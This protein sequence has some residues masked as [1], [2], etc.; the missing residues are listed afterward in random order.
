MV[1]HG[2]WVE[3]PDIPY[4]RQVLVFTILVKSGFLTDV[5]GIFV[6]PLQNQTSSLSAAMAFNELYHIYPISYVSAATGG[7]LTACT[8]PVVISFLFFP[9]FCGTQE[10]V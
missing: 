8:M 3:E 6:T 1:G 10:Q 5:N 7:I 2:M 9:V 4:G